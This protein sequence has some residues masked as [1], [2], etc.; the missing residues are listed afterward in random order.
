MSTR[1]KDKAYGAATLVVVWFIAAMISVLCCCLLLKIYLAKLYADVVNE[2]N[3]C[4]NNFRGRLGNDNGRLIC[5][6]KSVFSVRPGYPCAGAKVEWH[7]VSWV[8][9]SL[10]NLNPPSQTKTLRTEKVSQTNQYR[11]PNEL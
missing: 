11:I 1:I 5:L 4:D 2:L 7:Y 8:L 6:Q 9:S 3:V 10:E